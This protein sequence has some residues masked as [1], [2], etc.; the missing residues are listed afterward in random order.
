MNNRKAEH[1]DCAGNILTE[2]LGFPLGRIAMGEH[3]R[4]AK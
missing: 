1:R 4:V 3:G 2:M